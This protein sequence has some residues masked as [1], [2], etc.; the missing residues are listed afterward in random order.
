MAT[1]YGSPPESL[2]Y[3]DG[4]NTVPN[5]MLWR[6]RRISGMSKQTIKITP[7]T[8]QGSYTNNQ[9]ITCTL[10]MNSFLQ[11]STFTG[12]YTGKTN[13][14]GRSAGGP[15]QYQ[16]VRYFPRNT[17]SIIENLDVKIGSKTVQSIQQYNY[18]YNVLSDYQAG[19][20]AMS[21]NRINQ[22]ADPSNKSYYK[23]GRVYPQRGYPPGL[24]LTTHEESGRDAGNYTWRNWLGIFSSSSSTDIIHTDM[25]GEI[26][27]DITL[28]GSG[29]LMLGCDPGSTA[30]TDI[31][32]NSTFSGSSETNL[33]E[34][35]TITTQAT[36]LA[37]ENPGFTLSDVYFTIDRIDFPPE[38]YA[39][40]RD[41]L[42][43]GAVYKLYYPNYQPFQGAA[44]SSKT[45]SLRFNLTTESLNMLI[46]TFQVPTRDTLAVPVNSFISDRTQCEYGLSKATLSNLIAN[47]QAITFNNARYFLRNG[48]GL[49]TCSYKIGYDSLPS[50]TIPEQFESVLR[51]FGTQNDVLGGLYPGC[52]NLADYITCFYGHVLSLEDVDSQDIFTLS[53]LNSSQQPVS[54]EWNY[55]GGDDVSSAAD[56]NNVVPYSSGDCVPVVIAC[57]S[58]HV[59]FTIGRNSQ[60]YS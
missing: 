18:I 32:G 12:H 47:G 27:I 42:A 3:G 46:G 1:V 44:T 29:V 24:T 5:G 2:S 60:F 15:D 25:T 26:A 41:V 7:S 45:G 43:S 57:Y 20:D 52:K 23:N 40:M 8:G 30:I 56:A 58:S 49:K 39:A 9:K 21:K 59:D 4:F 33:E 14:A 19:L 17:Q 22:N 35:G 36:A 50:Q 11:L 48:S 16:R 10:P 55:V 31:C 6:L 54:I 13:H 53:G 51:A 37:A 34:K 38:I 28:A